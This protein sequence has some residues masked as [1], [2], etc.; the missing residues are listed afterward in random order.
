MSR[1]FSMVVRRARRVLE[2]HECVDLDEFDEVAKL[3][4]RPD[5]E[6]QHIPACT[7]RGRTLVLV[8]GSVTKKRADEL[9]CVQAPQFVIAV[10]GDSAY[11]VLRRCCDNH[12]IQAVFFAPA[13]G[14]N[15]V[16]EH[17]LVPPHE[18]L[19][20]GEVYHLLR[21]LQCRSTDDLPRMLQRDPVSCEELFRPG[22]VVVAYA[23]S[24]ARGVAAH[25]RA[26]T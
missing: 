20:E 26:V 5:G 25:P 8:A 11:R 15:S 21:A 17:K 3:A 14:L 9:L 18:L 23:P 1:S 12:H 6:L 2:R 19:S 24:R 10:V 16:L 7:R 22:D 4:A 13:T